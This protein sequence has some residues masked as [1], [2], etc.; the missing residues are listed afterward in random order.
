[1]KILEG[2]EN[3]FKE[4]QEELR[5]AQKIE[6]S[7][8]RDIEIRR[9]LQEIKKISIIEIEP[10][11]EL[12]DDVI[13]TIQKIKNKYTDETTGRYPSDFI[14]GGCYYLAYMLKQIYGDKATIYTSFSKDIHAITKIGD[15]FYDV[16]GVFENKDENYSESN[17]EQFDYF[18]DICH[19]YKSKE[20]IE[21]FEKRCDE[22]LEEIKNERKEKEQNPNKLS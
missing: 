1:M 22:I 2:H 12:E 17:N 5:K 7:N 4:L 10:I 9:I 16:N 13:S 3:E 18:I 15:K 11:D 20:S 19:I 6:D 21:I 8:L 14:N